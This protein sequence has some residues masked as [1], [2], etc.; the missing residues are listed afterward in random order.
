MR[1]IEQRL[2]LEHFEDRLQFRRRES[3]ANLG[4]QARHFARAQRREHAMSRLNQSVEG[5]RNRIC[6]RFKS[7]R[8][9]DDHNVGLHTACNLHRARA[10][11]RVIEPRGIPSA[12]SAQRFRARVKSG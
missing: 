7:A 2:R 3:F 4:D 11:R 8:R 12:I 5:G 10:A 1:A 6:Q 9:A